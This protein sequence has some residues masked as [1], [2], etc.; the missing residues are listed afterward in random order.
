MNNIYSVPKISMGNYIDANVPNVAIIVCL[1]QGADP[2]E[3][4][5]VVLLYA[6]EV[7]E[8]QFLL[9]FKICSCN[10]KDF[11]YYSNFFF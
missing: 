3:Q 5:I 11:M 9:M 1:L 8:R 7:L 6:E 2:N 4:D 10:A